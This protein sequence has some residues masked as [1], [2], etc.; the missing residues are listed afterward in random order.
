M[1][2]EF[3][4]TEGIV[5]LEDILEE[6]VGEIWDEHDEVEVDIEKIDDNTYIIDGMANLDD[7]FEYFEIDDKNTNVTTLNGWVMENTDKI[8]E[9]GDSFDYKDLHFEVIETDG[10]RAEKVKVT[11]TATE[12]EEQNEE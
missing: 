2:D 1:I 10:R 12:I 4:G 11:K 9:I 8:P 3:G 7:I 6:L 5:T